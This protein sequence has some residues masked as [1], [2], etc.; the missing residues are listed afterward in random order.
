MMPVF[1]VVTPLLLTAAFS[2]H[3]QL[4]GQRDWESEH[5]CC[6]TCST[7]SF[8]PGGCTIKLVVL[9]PVWRLLVQG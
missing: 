1:P 7:A 2:F 9:I 3:S 8:P 5:Y 6:L 4:K